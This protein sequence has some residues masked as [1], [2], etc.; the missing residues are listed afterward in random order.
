M[1]LSG[2]KRKNKEVKEITKLAGY[3]LGSNI[4]S[5]VNEQFE[6]TGNKL[7]RWQEV[8][9]RKTTSGIVIL[10]WLTSFL[11]FLYTLLT[12]II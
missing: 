10:L 5:K 8:I 6:I 4:R 7:N 11:Y 1:N 3:E 9:G 12:V 2:I